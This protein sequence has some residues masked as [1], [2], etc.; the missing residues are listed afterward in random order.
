MIQQLKF[1][2]MNKIALCV[3]RQL[4]NTD[5]LALHKTEKKKKKKKNAHTQYLEEMSSTSSPIKTTSTMK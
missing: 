5:A 1:E 3:R 2:I 4:K